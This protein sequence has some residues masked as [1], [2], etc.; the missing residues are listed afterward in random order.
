[1]PMKSLPANGWP[2]WTDTNANSSSRRNIDCGNHR[3]FPSR[4]ARPAG[5][6]LAH[7]GIAQAGYYFH[8]RE[9][10]R[11][12]GR[13]ADAAKACEETLQPRRAARSLPLQLL[14]AARV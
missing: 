8:S 7:D 4:H 9:R 6:T 10:P 11:R 1:M 3:K 2:V 12:F 13:R 5:L 14:E